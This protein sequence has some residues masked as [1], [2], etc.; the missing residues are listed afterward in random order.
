MRVRVLLCVLA[1]FLTGCTTGSETVADEPLVIRGG[2]ALVGPGLESIEDSVIVVRDG[3]IDAVGPAAQIPIPEDSK[4]V[5]AT[6][7]TIVPGFID[8]HVHIGFAEPASVLTGGVTTVRD[9]GWPPER[10]WPL[11]E[12]SG[13]SDFDGP[14]IL[15]AGQMLTVKKGYPTRAGW[16]PKGTGLVVDGP[17]DAEAAV[18]AQIERGA[19]TIKVSLNPLVGPTLDVETLSAIVAAARE[20]GLHTTGHV[21]GLAELDKALAA[22]MDELAHMLMSPERIPDGTI[23][24]MV[25]RGM[26][27]V[28]TLSVRTGSDKDIAIDNLERFAAAGGRVIYGT[29]LG[30]AGP[31]PGIDPLEVTAMS[32]AG[33]SGRDIIR[34]ATVDS[35]TWLGLGDVG[36]LAEGATAD[37][38]GMN[39]DPLDDVLAMT[40]IS[41]VIRRGNLVETSVP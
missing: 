24:K 10:I 18:V 1:I 34:S 38:V 22:G 25:Q 32:Q 33:L 13:S 6:G 19:T 5:D 36:V 16:A 27:V 3:L 15:A 4:V 30:N 20:R 40:D 28:P 2:T 14:T 23:A 12:A 17:A 26:A 11:V 8:A 29:D 41:F 37:I 39:G 9:L 7:M 35:A 31:R 21:Y